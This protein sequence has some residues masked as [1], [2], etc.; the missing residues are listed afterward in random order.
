VPEFRLVV[1]SLSG[2]I[3]AK[4]NAIVSV[5]PFLSVTCARNENVPEFVGVPEKVPSEASVTPAG[6]LPDT[7]VQV[8]GGFPPF[9][10]SAW[11]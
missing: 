2:A 10:L 11:L 9:A 8:Y 3:T 1:V 4:L 5:A 7:T 6:R